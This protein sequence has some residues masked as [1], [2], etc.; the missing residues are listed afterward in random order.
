MDNK[1]MHQSFLKKSGRAVC[2]G[3]EGRGKGMGDRGEG[4][5]K[6]KELSVCM[7]RGDMPKSSL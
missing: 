7:S 3:A 2:R 6:S 5:G 4:K 1:C